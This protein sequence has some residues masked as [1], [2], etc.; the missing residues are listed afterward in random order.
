MHL[1]CSFRKRFNNTQLCHRKSK[2]G[3][4]TLGSTIRSPLT[5]SDAAVQTSGIEKSLVDGS[6]SKFHTDHQES[7]LW[8]GKSN[9]CSYRR[10]LACLLQFT[11]SRTVVA[12]RRSFGGA[13]F[14]SI[15]SIVI[16]LIIKFQKLT[17]LCC[18]AVYRFCWCAHRSAVFS[19]R[20][21][22]FQ[23]LLLS[24]CQ[25]VSAPS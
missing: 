19:S 13:M 15:G 20:I 12:S 8:S 24:L 17:A 23:H 5:G 22:K 6:G 14:A 4:R 16:A 9:I 2:P 1:P 18:S 3:G 25:S 11:S 21:D 7:N 10:D